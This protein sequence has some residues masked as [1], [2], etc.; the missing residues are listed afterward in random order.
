[1]YEQ[2]S[3]FITS[4]LRCNVLIQSYDGTDIAKG[5][6]IIWHFIKL[7]FCFIHKPTTTKTFKTASILSI[8]DTHVFSN[9]HHAKIHL[10]PV[11]GEINVR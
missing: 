10:I 8:T 2:Q 7:C 6:F 5:V 11:P 4:K 3:S 1:M 9:N